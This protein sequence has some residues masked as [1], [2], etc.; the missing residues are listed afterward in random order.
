MVALAPATQL[1]FSLL[2]NHETSSLAILL[3]VG[4]I[5]LINM[6]HTISLVSIQ[7][8]AIKQL[9][10]LAIVPYSDGKN[11]PSL[12]I[13]TCTC[14]ANIRSPRGNRKPRAVRCRISLLKQSWLGARM[15][16]DVRKLKR[17]SWA[18]T[19]LIRPQPHF[20]LSEFHWLHAE[21]ETW[22]S[23]TFGKG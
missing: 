18:R 13:L 12:R 22:S 3:V 21:I 20:L 7:S 17:G 10:Y 14:T 11:P 1:E 8:K 23:F 6:N 15:L 4:W 9:V 16:R 2:S 5:Y 19:K